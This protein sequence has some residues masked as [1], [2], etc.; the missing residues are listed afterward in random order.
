M[1]RL[2]AA[3]KNRTVTLEENRKLPVYIIYLTARIGA[4]DRLQLSPDLY[5]RDA[6]LAAAL[7]TGTAPGSLH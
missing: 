5:N 6:I 4:D 2:L 3:G 1:Q 7:D